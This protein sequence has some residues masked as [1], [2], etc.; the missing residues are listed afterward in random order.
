MKKREPPETRSDRTT[1]AGA[2]HALG[3]KS[4]FS[5]WLEEFRCIMTKSAAFVDVRHLRFAVAA[6]D[7]RSFR[8][9]AELLCIRQSTL[10][11]SVREFEPHVLPGSRQLLM[12]GRTIQLGVSAATSFAFVLH[13]LATNAAKYGALFR[14][15]NVDA[16]DL[17][18]GVR[19]TQKIRV[20]RPGTGSPGTTT[21]LISELFVRE[22]NIDGRSFHSVH[23]LTLCSR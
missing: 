22:A 17:R 2:R 9:A 14:R 19:R 3:V 21:H 7:H 4:T 23:P 11:R 13:E 5:L 18:M 1:E 12:R 6:A 8:R 10:S 15:R 16:L 20:S